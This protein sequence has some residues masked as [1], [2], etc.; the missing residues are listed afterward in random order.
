LVILITL[1]K[2]GYCSLHYKVNSH[3][4]SLSRFKRETLN[5]VPLLPKRKKGVGDEVC[6]I[7]ILS[8]PFAKAFIPKK[9]TPMD[10]FL[11]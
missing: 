11:T 2:I 6:K 1:G 4:K 9:K 8:F 10:W 5:P 7:G 3:S